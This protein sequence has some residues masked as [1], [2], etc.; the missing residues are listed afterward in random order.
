MTGTRTRTQVEAD[1]GRPAWLADED[2]AGPTFE[3]QILIVGETPAGLAL[4]LALRRVGY[5][6]IL[7]RGAATDGT[8]A[9]PD[10]RYLPEPVLRIL[11]TLGVGETVRER[12]R[13]VR[14]TGGRD[15]AVR[16]DS[17]EEARIAV[18]RSGV[19]KRVLRDALAT[20]RSGVDRT[21]ASVDTR[22][23]AVEATFDHGV[24]EWFDL[25]VAAGRG[26]P[27]MPEVESPSAVSLTQGV[28]SD[29]AVAPEGNGTRGRVPG[30]VHEEIPDPDGGD[31]VHRVTAADGS[32]PGAVAE[33]LDS[34]GPRTTTFDQVPLGDPGPTAQWGSGPV[35]RCGPGAVPTAPASGCRTALAF[36]DVRV[37][38]ERL[39]RGPR[40]VPA[41]V[42]GYAGR[43]RTDVA[44]LWQRAAD[45]GDPLSTD[46]PD[47]LAA[48]AALRGV[49]SRVAS[50]PAFRAPEAEQE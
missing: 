7:A 45:T 16:E 9:E 18:L 28:A 15:T 2:R 10:L 34:R 33:F 29:P 22:D 14:L 39:A 1:G 32:V 47:G 42:N 20:G 40:S 49:V 43:R 17:P 41:V 38:A 12:A 8:A 36:G 30:A 35:A 19:L 50:S 26:G 23:G 6:P 24:R 44:G 46:L 11:D 25:A 3:R 48:V 13:M 31:L 37:L 4:G 27:A 21:V 5:D